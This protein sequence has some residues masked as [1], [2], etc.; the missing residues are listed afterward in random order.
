MNVYNVYLIWNNLFLSNMF[1]LTTEGHKWS[2]N[3]ERFGY[4]FLT[5]LCFIV[6]NST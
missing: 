5:K 6:K 1:F 3:T 2:E 4:I